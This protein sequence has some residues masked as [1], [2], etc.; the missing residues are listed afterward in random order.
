MN[1][2][3]TCQTDSVD[4]DLPK[5]TF[6]VVCCISF[7]TKITTMKQS[8]I[9]AK[10]KNDIAIYNC[11]KLHRQSHPSNH[12]TAFIPPLSSFELPVAY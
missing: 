10:N 2:D 8:R 7:S 3:E 1:C 11:K 6:N 5:P 12:S 9:S 4:T